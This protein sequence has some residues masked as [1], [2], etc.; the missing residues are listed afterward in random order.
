MNDEVSVPVSWIEGLLTVCE[1][2]KDFTDKWVDADHSI[3]ATK[4][5]I[6]SQELLGYARSA[7]SLLPKN[8]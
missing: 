6:R 5:L 4:V 2:Y 7:K 3:E 8:K 1:K